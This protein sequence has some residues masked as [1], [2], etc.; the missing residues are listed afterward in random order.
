MGA[1]LADLAA[2]RA[3]L[4]KVIDLGK[5]VALTDVSGS[6]SGQP[7]ERRRS[8]WA[9]WLRSAPAPRSGNVC[10]PLRAGCSGSI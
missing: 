4:P 10:S 3:A 2:L 5:L 8:G 7:L 9:S 6:M 1:G